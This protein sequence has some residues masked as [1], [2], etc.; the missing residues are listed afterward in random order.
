[1]LTT[2]GLPL[3]EQ[4]VELVSLVYGN[5]NYEIEYTKFLADCAEPL[6]YIINAP[7]SGARSTYVAKFTDF[8][9][10]KAMQ[11]LM[12]KIKNIIKKDR[13]RMLEFFQDH[14]QLRKGVVQPTQFRSTL[15]A[16]NVQLTSAEYALLEKHYNV[17]NEAN[18]PL[19]NYVDFCEEIA[20]I[21]TEKDLEK[22]PTKTLKGFSAPSILDPKDVLNADEEKCLHDCMTR[23]GTHVRHHRLLIKPFFQDKD[24]SSSGFV[25]MTRFRSI[26]DNMKLQ[27]SEKEFA[28]INKRFQAK[29]AN[30]I[31]YVEF[32]WVLRHYSGDLE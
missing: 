3:T 22:N 29:A 1:M 8:N 13:I 7:Y 9:G 23:L 11:A 26:F 2:H 10:D 30:E 25:S 5:E 4:E 6:T 14:D 18:A 15:H 28:M 17:P 12:V 24:K 31:N 16:H 19:V 21:F 27:A 20:K 32:D